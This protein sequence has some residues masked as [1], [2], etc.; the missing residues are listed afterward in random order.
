MCFS[1][2]FFSWPLY[3]KQNWQYIFFIYKKSAVAQ[4]NLEK[5]LLAMW[6][7]RSYNRG[8]LNLKREGY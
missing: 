5:A 3:N 8:G 7:K 4:Q 1:M 6:Q 2:F